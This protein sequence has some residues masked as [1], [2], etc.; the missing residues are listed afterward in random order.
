[1]AVEARRRELQCAAAAAVTGVAARR[2]APAAVVGHDGVQGGVVHPQAPQAPA[3]RR[4][5]AQGGSARACARERPSGHRSVSGPSALGMLP[6][7]YS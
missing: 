2:G 4:E 1:M 3:H 7:T 6:A 5:G